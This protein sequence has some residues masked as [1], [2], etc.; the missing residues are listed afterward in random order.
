MSE[1]LTVKELE[2]GFSK[3]AHMRNTML[4]DYVALPLENTW[5]KVM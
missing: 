3:M 1:A 2:T 5:E 4:A